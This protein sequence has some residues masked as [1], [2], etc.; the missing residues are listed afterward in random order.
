LV[1]FI[2]AEICLN[3]IFGYA[4]VGLAAKIKIYKTIVQPAVVFGSEK[5]A[6]ADM[7]KKRLARRERK[8]LRRI[9]GPVVVQGIWRIRTTHELREQ[10]K[11]LDVGMGWACSKNGSRK[12][13]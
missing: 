2:G 12:E 1:I 8:I 13:S 7:D 4:I 10:N 9:Y 6:M 5:W 3:G 11:D